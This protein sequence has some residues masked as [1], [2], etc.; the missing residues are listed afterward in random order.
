[1]IRIVCMLLT[2][3]LFSFDV[4]L[5]QGAA[6]SLDLVR[7]TIIAC[8]A[9]IKGTS[10]VTATMFGPTGEP[11]KVALTQDQPGFYIGQVAIVPGHYSL[12]AQGGACEGGVRL[13]V[14]PAHS[15]NLTVILRE[16]GRAFYD[17]SAYAAGALPFEGVTS[18]Y[19]TARDGTTIPVT[20]DGMAFYAEGLPLGAYTLS[21][22]FYDQNLLCRLP[23]NV[24]TPG[25][26][27]NISARDTKRC[28]GRLV[29]VGGRSQHFQ[30]LW[31]ATNP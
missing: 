18:A 31:P 2:L 22:S 3:I 13:T 12:A 30:A 6:S 25:L 4:S 11:K 27:L 7:V 5:A 9:V 23:I 26:I 15:R 20:L 14:L 28:L 24:V 17:F 16:R 29:R 19:L 8:P 10:D 1:M 21:L